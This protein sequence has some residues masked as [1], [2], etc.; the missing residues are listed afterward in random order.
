M[1]TPGYTSYHNRIQYQ[2][3]DIKP[4][5]RQENR[6][7]IGLGTGW[8]NGMGWVQGIART[9][10]RPSLIAWKCEEELLSM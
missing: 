9:D 7:S 2:R 4:L 1:L 3:Y 8:A 5:L 6:I 10:F